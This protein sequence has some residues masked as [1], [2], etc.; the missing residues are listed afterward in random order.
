MQKREMLKIM[1]EEMRNFCILVVSRSLKP[2][3]Y[4][5]IL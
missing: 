2:V 1:D 4:V 5:C 3:Y